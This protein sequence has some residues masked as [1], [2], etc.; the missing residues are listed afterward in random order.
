[1]EADSDEE[2]DAFLPFHP[3][4]TWKALTEERESRNKRYYVM[5]TV[6]LHIITYHDHDHNIM[7]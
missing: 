4:Q 1:M 2:C 3:R 7:F 6:I 5:L